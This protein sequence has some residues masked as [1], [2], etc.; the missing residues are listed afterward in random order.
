M[1]KLYHT[2]VFWDGS[3]A[4]FSVQHLMYAIPA[5]ICLVVVV[6]PFPLVLLLDGVLIKIESYLGMK[7]QC[8]KNMRP[9]GLPLHVKV[10]P[11]L[12]SFQGCFKDKYRFF[13]GMFYI[14]CIVILS[15]LDRPCF[16]NHTILFYS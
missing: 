4:Y 9:Y 12:D 1:E 15:I 7:Y 16:I 11:L 10:K 3:I 5:I 13:S 14:Y 8:I 6:I 2:V